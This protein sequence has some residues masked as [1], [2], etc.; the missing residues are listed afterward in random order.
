MWAS[1][2]R[3][4]LHIHR[5]FIVYSLTIKVYFSIIRRIF[6]NLVALYGLLPH[7]TD[8]GQRQ[9][10]RIRTIP[11]TDLDKLLKE[12][13]SKGPVAALPRNLPDRWLRALGR[14]LARAQKANLEGRPEDPSVD[15][16]APLF[17]VA[18]FL[19]ATRGIAPEQISMSPLELKEGIDR[20]SDAI[21]NEIIGR[22][23]GVFVRDFTLENIV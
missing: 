20:F 21:H 3:R 6:A 2:C 19:T 23:T 15:I 17:V 16:S 9:M 5:A 13:L 18:S 7:R 22:E 10:R 11:K 14:D 1:S 4:L 8:C 12:V